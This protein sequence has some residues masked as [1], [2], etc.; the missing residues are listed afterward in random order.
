MHYIIIMAT[1]QSP[2]EFLKSS[3]TTALG[4]LT[5]Q[6]AREYGEHHLDNW[7]WYVHCP[8]NPAHRN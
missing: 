4:F 6:A 5:E 1:I 2:P 7:E 3:V 8:S